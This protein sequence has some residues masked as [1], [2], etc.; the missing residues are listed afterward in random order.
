MSNHTPSH[1]TLTVRL[2][3]TS[4]SRQLASL[5][6]LDSAPVPEGALIVAESDGRIVAAKPLDGGRAVADPFVRTAALVQL[7]ELRAHQLREPSSTSQPGFL[8][9]LAM[10]FDRPA[11]RV[12]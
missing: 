10:L 3:R 11:L 7:L 5:A 4:D 8:T 12:N 9:R 1:D 2:A 6:A